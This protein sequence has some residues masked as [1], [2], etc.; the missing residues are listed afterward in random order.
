MSYQAEFTGWGSLTIEDF[1]VAYRKA[2]AD[3]V[4][5]PFLIVRMSRGLARF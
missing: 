3:R 2:K 4:I 5:P 1:L